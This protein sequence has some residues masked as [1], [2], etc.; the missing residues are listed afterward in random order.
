MEETKSQPITKQ[1][2][3]KAWR[4]VRA[5]RGSAGID[6][7]SIHK[8]ES[9]LKGNL[10]KLWN[11]LASGS[12]FPQPV[13]Q[14]GIRKGTGGT[15]FLG[16]PTVSDRI[17]QMVVKEYLEPSIDLVFHPNSYGYRAGRSAHDALAAARQNCWKWDWVIDLDIK[18]FFD[19]IDHDL[20]MLAVRKHPDEKW[21]LMYIQR[22]LEAPVQTEE[23]LREIQGTGTPQGSVISPLLSNLFLHYAFDRWMDKT[24]GGL[25]FE[26]YADD[27]IVHC[28]SREQAKY[29]LQMIRERMA[30]CKLEL[31]PEK[32]K[33]VYCGDTRRPMEYE[34]I[35]FTFLG[36]TFRPREGFNRKKGT[37]FTTFTPAISRGA[38]KEFGRRI[39]SMELQNRTGATLE[40]LAKEVNRIAR[41]YINYFGKYMKTDLHSMFFRLNLTLLKWARH[42]YKRLRTR[43]R[44]AVKWLKRAAKY[45]PNLFVHWQF[46]VRP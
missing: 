28:R 38:V 20:L 21:V 30:E 41:G 6:G 27:I 39:R 19:N 46:G 10:Y 9:D 34:V 44:R 35:N 24:T 5:N 18:G 36:Y 14:V 23:G 13:K 17:A 43:K 15:R 33:I 11:R 1:M 4:K 25:E 32:T 3:W 31:H 8:F 42:K 40:Q 12:Y 37:H 29:V 7:V 16:V 45:N 26:R 2:V 22:W